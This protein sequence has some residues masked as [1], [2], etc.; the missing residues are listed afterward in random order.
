MP[1]LQIEMQRI[2][3]N[4]RNLRIREF[5]LKNGFEYSR[6][7][8]EEV[9]KLEFSFKNGRVPVQTLEYYQPAI[10]NVCSKNWGLIGNI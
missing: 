2:E 4:V 5:I 3:I 9:D 7:L 1:Q 10:C 6:E 8:I